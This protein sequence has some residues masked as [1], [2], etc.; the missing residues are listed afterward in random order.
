MP[1]TVKDR[2]LQRQQLIHMLYSMIDE[3]EHPSKRRLDSG[4]PFNIL[5]KSAYAGLD[6]LQW[7]IETMVVPRI[8]NRLECFRR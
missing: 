3:L 6:G 2:E 8:E 4:F 5:E 1:G 7:I